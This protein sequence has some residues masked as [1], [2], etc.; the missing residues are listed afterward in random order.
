MKITIFFSWQS[1]TNAKYNRRFILKCIEDAVKKLKRKPNLSDVEFKI[2]EGINGEPGSVQV[3]ETIVEQ[4]IPNCDIFIADLSVINKPTKLTKLFYTLLGLKHNLAINSNVMYEYG[5]AKNALGE[6][7]IIG[8]LNNYYGSPLDDTNTIPFDI[9]HNR[10]P[11]EYKYSSKTRDLGKT[12]ENLINNLYGAIKT[13]T[14]YVIGNQKT[15]Y[16]PLIPW[17]EW[18]KYIQTKHSFI[19]NNKIEQLRSELI[20]LA[21]A[22]RNNF[23]VIGQPGIGKTRT[24][25][26]IFRERDGDDQSKLLSARVLYVNCN[27]HSNYDFHLLLQKIVDDKDDKIIVLDNCSKDLHRSL[28]T[29]VES[30]DSKI[31]LITVDSNPEEA[32]DIISNIRYFFIKRGDFHDVAERI[33][34][35]EANLIGDENLKRIKDFAQGNSLMATLL[36][37]SIKS[38]GKIVGKLEDKDLLDRLLGEK[39]RDPRNRTML[40]SCSL[41]NYI[42]FE[43][44]K[45]E[46]IDFIATNKNITSIDG[47][48]EVLKHDFVAI[49]NYYIKREIVEKRGRY[50]GVRPLP[51]AMYLAQEWMD[52]C[53][54]NKFLSVI[55]DIAGLESQHRARLSEAFAEQMKYLGYDDKANQIIGKI[56]GENGPFDNAEVLNTEL[57][58]RLFRSFVEV[59]PIAV[60]ENLY[61]NF[62]NKTTAQLSSIKEG[63]RNLI[64]VLEKL[65]FDRRTFG[66]SIKVLLKFAVAENENISNNATGQFLQLFN[67]QLAGTEANLTERLDAI[68]WGLQQNDERFKRLI[69]SAL[70][71]GLKGRGFRRDVGAEYQGTHVLKDYEPDYSEIVHYFDEIIRILRDLYDNDEGSKETIENIVIERLRGL[72]RAR[73]GLLILYFLEEIMSKKNFFWQEGLNSLRLVRDYD[74][75]VMDEESKSKIQQLIDVLTKD[76][77][78]SKYLD[79]QRYIVER[80]NFEETNKRLISASEDLADEFFDQDVKWDEVF[81]A[82]FSKNNG[83]PGFYFGKRLYENYGDDFELKWKFLS[84]VFDTMSAIAKDQ[85]NPSIIIGFLSKATSEI[86]DKV[87]RA[88]I[89]NDKLDSLLFEIIGSREIS[90]E[91]L[92]PLFSLID[93]KQDKVFDFER[94]R[95]I[96]SLALEEMEIFSNRLFSFGKEGYQV[97]FNILFDYSFDDALKKKEL[98]ELFKKCYLELGVTVEGQTTIDN[99]KWFKTLTDILENV[100]ESEFAKKINK[101]F[102]YSIDR[103][104]SF[105]WDHDIL[106]LYYTLIKYHFD[107]VWPYISDVLISSEKDYDRFHALT[108]IFQSNIST[109]NNMS[110]VSVLFSGNIDRIFEWCHDNSPEAPTIIADLAPIFAGNNDDFKNWHPVAT[111]LIDEF[112]TIRSVLSNISANI[113]SFSSIGSVVPYLNVQ[114]E[115]FNKLISHPTLEVSEWAKANIGYIEKDIKQERT[116]DEEEYLR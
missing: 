108:S 4:R 81:P 67:I 52:T 3:A 59:N 40:R 92:D 18:A 34:D 8:V 35:E 9:R 105:T 78:L 77:F 111:R 85:R 47:S 82:I 62:F 10:F 109:T 70:S 86:M 104:R 113:G 23:R 66:K 93:G 95:S 98:T 53:D 94:V 1:T 19:V 110:N 102:I 6:R 101:E 54:D 36:V 38:G 64:W 65:C 29:L 57:G 33:I 79:S 44:D 60:S 15:N 22:P 48:E 56:V 24:L 55:T 45:R 88:L 14:E 46:Q 7:R 12:K 50:I 63:R 25:F 16:L 28:K 31:S 107:V 97:A 89:E 103:Y 51:L 80:R 42:G 58:S 71:V 90:I 96:G 99:Y 39:G 68:K 112:G 106:N 20:G 116:R 27:D 73:L 114:R 5:I 61:R 49:C 17:T 87:K 37:D 43:A 21:T 26:E 69:L 72:C 84:V 2:Q 91:D 41:F 32:H 13:A 75:H 115:L 74:F 100:E 83:V 11:I 30:V 76:D